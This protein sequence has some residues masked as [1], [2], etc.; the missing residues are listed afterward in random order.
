MIARNDDGVP[1]FEFPN[2]AG[3]P[4]VRHGV[5]TRTGG[6][7]SA[8]YAS[9]NVGFGVGDRPEVV[10]SNRGIVSRCMGDLS[11]VFIRQV[12][13]AGVVVLKSGDAHAPA[14]GRPLTGD[15]LVT[16]IRGTGLVI[17]TADCQA[18]MLFDPR[19][20]VA[21]NIHSGWRGSVRNIIGE[22]VR[23]MTSRF[24]CDPAD[25]RAGIG[26][27]LGPCCGEFVHYR[28]EIPR[29]FWKYKGRNRHFD[30]WAASRDQLSAAGILE[31]NIFS[32]GLCTRCRTDLFFSYR[33]ERST[34]RMAMVIGLH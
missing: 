10:A 3:Q 17:Q 4:G 24:G 25:I 20:Q 18:V 26:P 9:L 13:G 28:E 2:L 32:S 16:D 11:L 30:F 19:K 23:A 34:G 6:G 1:F 21:A 29:E 14:S 5:F 33:K 12:H 31:E 7:G 8:P 27:S 15:A 22:T